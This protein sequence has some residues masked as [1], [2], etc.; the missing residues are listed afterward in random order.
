MWKALCNFKEKG[1]L[2]GF[3]PL[4][5]F[6]RI[7]QICFDIILNIQL[8]QVH[9]KWRLFMHWRQQQQQV[10]SHERVAM[11]NLHRVVVPVQH[12]PAS[13]TKVWSLI[14]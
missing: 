8:F 14:T 10:S 1:C 7:H 4:L 13:C 11:G 9:P 2:K 5:L 6:S 12:D 3:A